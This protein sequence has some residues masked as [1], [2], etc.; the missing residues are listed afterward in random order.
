MNTDEHGYFDALAE[1]VPGAVFEVSNAPG[2][3]FLERVSNCVPR[4]G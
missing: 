1:R 4:A 2:A 3:G